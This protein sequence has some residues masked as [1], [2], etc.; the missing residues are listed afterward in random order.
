MT[1]FKQLVNDCGMTLTGAAKLLK[2]SKK[3]LDAY[4]QGSR[5]PPPEVL[6]KLE[7]YKL[8]AQLIFKQS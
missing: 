5:N 2:K 6:K 3:T 7:Q 1:E 4:S 8:A